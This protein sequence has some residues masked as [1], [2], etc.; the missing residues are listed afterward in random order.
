MLKPLLVI[1]LS[2]YI[3]KI[4]KHEDIYLPKGYYVNANGIIS[5]I[6]LQLKS[7]EFG[8]G[9][10]LTYVSDDGSGKSFDY[11][12]KIYTLVRII[13]SENYELLERKN[14]SNILVKPNFV[15]PSAPIVRPRTIHLTPYGSLWISRAFN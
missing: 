9:M 15:N 8:K 6:N 3:N 7:S 13:H 2:K 11:D 1:K 12:S 10:Y 5:A 14:R 4:E